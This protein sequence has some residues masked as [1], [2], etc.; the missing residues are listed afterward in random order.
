[1]SVEF[2]FEFYSE[3][4]D[5]DDKFRLESERRLLALSEG[6]D[7][8]IGASVNLEELTGETTPHR[9]QATVVAFKRPQNVAA[10]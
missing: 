2:S 1:M 5:P 6:H 9:F 8:L 4:P 7:D 10:T 3:I